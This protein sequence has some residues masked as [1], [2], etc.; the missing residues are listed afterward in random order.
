MAARLLPLPP[1]ASPSFMPGTRVT[2]VSGTRKMSSLGCGCCVAFSSRTCRNSQ[3][4]RRQVQGGVRFHAATPELC[5]AQTQ[6]HAKECGR[7]R[8]WFGTC[9]THNT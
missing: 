6:Q 7:E 1:K 2:R 3:Q 8:C 4:G 5:D 9:C